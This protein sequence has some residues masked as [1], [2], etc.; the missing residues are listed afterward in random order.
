MKM[1]K[2]QN[3]TDNHQG[4]PDTE[5]LFGPDKSTLPIS[6]AK[7]YVRNYLKRQGGLSPVRHKDE[8]TKYLYIDIDRLINIINVWN[9]DRNGRNLFDLNRSAERNID[10]IRLYPMIYSNDYPGDPERRSRLNLCLVPV[11]NGNEIIPNSF[12][13][14]NY[15]KMFG[16]IENE[17]GQCPPPS[18]CP[19]TGATLLN[20][21][22]GIMHEPPDSN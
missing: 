10:S 14:D 20:A 19:P 15:I 4:Q 7:K 18:P 2:E 12:T 5:S 17:I 8:N 9:N 13:E 3:N 1:E 21:A 6:V 16:E 11:K 22:M